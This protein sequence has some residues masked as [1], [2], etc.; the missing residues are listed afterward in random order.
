MRLRPV[1]PALRAIAPLLLAIVAA[2]PLR[3]APRPRTV[4]VLSGGGARGAAHVGVLKVL[5]EERVP[6]DLVIGTS[7]GAVVGGLWASGM[8]PAE[9]EG[10]MT[11]VDWARAFTDRADRRDLSYRRK[12]DD[13]DH[14]VPVRIGFDG[15]EPRFP[16]GVLEGR[17]VLTLLRTLTLPVAE[18][19]SFDRLRVPFRAIAT[20]L[21]TGERVVLDG[22]EL[23][24]AMR[25]SLSIPAVFDPVEIG[26][27][28]LVDGGIAENLGIA[29]AR[30]M[31]AERIIAVDISTPL[32][33]RDRIDDALGVVDQ[34]LTI[35][36]R[37]EADRLAASLGPA[38]LLLRPPLDEIG[39]AAFDRAAA[40]IRVGEATARAA[41]DRLRPFAASESEWA[42]S[43]P[44][45]PAPRPPAVVGNVVIESDGD[46]DPAMAT[47]RIRT[48]PGGELDLPQLVADLERLWG[49]GIFRNVDFHLEP[50]AAPGE[51]DLRI[52]LDER[53][54]GRD[55]LRIGFRLI[56]DFDGT[57]SYDL[58]VRY[59]RLQVNRLG[60]EGRFDLRI[61]ERQ[62]AIAGFY[63]PLGGRGLFL[64]ARGGWEAD[65]L[66]FVVD[67]LEVA[68]YRDRGWTGE[69]A[70]GREFGNWGAL[71]LEGRHRTA[72][73]EL[74]SGLLFEP[75]I[76]LD[77][78]SLSASFDV[79]TLDDPRFPGAG[80]HA[81]VRAG[82]WFDSPFGEDDA[83][84]AWV[85][86]FAATTLGRWRTGGGLE[87][88]TT[89]R[90][91]PGLLPFRL[92]GPRRLSGLRE[93]ELFGR[94]SGLAFLEAS[95]LVGGRS[96][97]MPI[98]LGG[99][100][101]AGG[102]WVA[103][104]DVDDEGILLGGSLFVGV[105]SMLG[106]FTLGWGWTEG[107]RNSVFLSLGR[108]F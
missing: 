32:L 8:S 74:K 98:W 18:V 4:L 92:G 30:E 22:G 15:L 52:V 63:Q 53:T 25:A 51:T 21:E 55:D 1:R 94:Y 6:V 42:A 89:F 61:G 71:R 23:A 106:P 93:D 77:E 96:L 101:E 7:M 29:L 90:D 73:G 70:V 76:D 31:G 83:T 78:A 104:D 107:G 3:A 27:R 28:L 19:R 39:S 54:R 5:E 84:A 16:L 69:F 105:D 59:S 95:R 46:L 37:R 82:H 10:A 49:L 17:R 97:R 36:I 34:T 43:H 60:G 20:D 48:R 58:G 85:R 88:G 14:L 41:I 80:M 87:G 65:D 24:L 91:E 72:V 11:Q 102:I 12:Q 57:T 81:T 40:A 108:D 38:D 56:D 67:G 9:I 33:D 68:L 75:E 2:P 35:L 103:R 50:S 47:R 86:L 79:D 99:S 44:P 62:R 45:G 64:E 100:V 13:H 66:P 26:G